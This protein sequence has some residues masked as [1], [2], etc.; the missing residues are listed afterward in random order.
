MSREH[1]GLGDGSVVACG[2]VVIG[3]M[4]QLEKVSHSC[5]HQVWG[6]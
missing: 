5:G 3:D 1:I 2:G 6:V 4:E